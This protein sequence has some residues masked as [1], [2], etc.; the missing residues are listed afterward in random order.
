MGA[1]YG[2]STEWFP[3][4][5]AGRGTLYGGAVWLFADEIAMPALGLLGPLRTTPLSSLVSAL[6]SHMSYGFVTDFLFQTLGFGK[7]RNLRSQFNQIAPCRKSKNM[8]SGSATSFFV[9]HWL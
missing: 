2:L 1:L 7:E 9:A 4:V 8:Y 5:G 3:I 6:A